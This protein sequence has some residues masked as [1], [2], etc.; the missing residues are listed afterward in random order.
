[1]HYFVAISLFFSIVLHGQDYT[2]TQLPFEKDLIP[3]GIAVDTKNQKVFLNS[4]R[5]NKIVRCNLD[6]TQPEEFLESNA[7]GYLSGFGMTIKG[8]TLY[9]LGNSLPKKNNTSILLLLHRET[10]ALLESHKLSDSTT[11]YLNDLAVG[12][13]GAVFIT[14]S[15]SDAIYTLNHTTNKLEVFFRHPGIQ[16]SNGIALSDDGTLLYLA[17]YSNGIRVLNLATKELVNTPNAY[18]GIDG[19]KYYDNHLIGIVNGNRDGG[20]NGVYRYHLSDDGRIVNT[21][22]KVM[23][24]RDPSDIPTTFDISKETVY[25][26]ADIQLDNFNQDT[27]AIIDES[28]LKPYSLIQLDIA[29]IKDND[30]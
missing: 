5:K 14:D 9:A 4:L 20:K 28:L 29:K 7:Y 30:H 15:E 22:E 10:G 19:M 13:N 11:I 21:R 8:D 26:I 2:L 3:E 6:G 24:L 27:N 1:M 23:D 16:Y 17:T 18:K 12:A 25:F